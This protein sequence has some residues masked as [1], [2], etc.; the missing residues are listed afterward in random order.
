MKKH[1]LWIT[2]LLHTAVVQAQTDIWKQLQIRQSM[3]TAETREEPAQ[4]LLTL[5]KDKDASWVMD[6][7]VA[8]KF[9]T[10]D[11]GSTSFS[12]KILSEFHRNTQT[13]KEQNNFQ[14]GY[15]Y[16]LQLITAPAGRTSYYLEG[17]IKYAYDGMAINHSLILDAT[18]TPYRAP[19]GNT[20]GPYWNAYGYRRHYSYF[21][22]PHIGL[23]GQE[24]F[25]APDGKDSTE[26]L[27]LRPLFDLQAVFRYNYESDVN[28]PNP[29]A[30]PLLEL[31]L[32]YVGRYD[33]VNTTS[34]KEDYTNLFT[35]GLRYYPIKSNEVKASVGLSYNIGSDPAKGLAQQSYWLFSINLSK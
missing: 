25:K 11:P 34:G 3:E 33:V 23:Q 8:Y 10:N 27:I 16:W 14:L 26:G 12:S 15:G 22:S 24:V 13:D 2:F 9:N 30:T 1:I 17:D 32:K 35:A 19:G 4:L 29:N 20:A 7:G 5:P 6:I 21:L 18:V 28:S 31:S